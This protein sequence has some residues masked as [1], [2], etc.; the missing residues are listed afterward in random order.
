M[1]KADLYN[2]SNILQRRDAK[3]VIEEF[4]HLLCSC[5]SAGLES[6]DEELSDRTKCQE[7]GRETSRLLDI[8][9]GSG[10]VLVD[11]VLPNFHNDY[12]LGTDISEEMVR[13]AKESYADLEDV[14]FSQLDIVGDVEAF[15]RNHSPFDHVTSFYCLHWI[16]NQMLALQNIHKLLKPNGNCLLAFISNMAIFDIYEDMAQTTRWGKFMY[17]VDRYISPYQHVKDPAEQ[18]TRYLEEIGFRD[19]RVEAKPMTFHYNGVPLLKSKYNDAV[20]RCIYIF[21]RFN[22]LISQFVYQQ[23]R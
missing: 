13:Y 18:A 2:R 5:G 10:D 11:F 22:D 7:K 9:T 1:N 8:G 12:L 21:R 16:Q 4:G 6:S 3:L 17:D 20:T 15:L 19:I 14:E 23:K